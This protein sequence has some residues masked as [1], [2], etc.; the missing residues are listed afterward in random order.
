M[1]YDPDDGDEDEEDPEAPAHKVTVSSA[2]G[3]FKLTVKGLELEGEYRKDPL[4]IK[5]IYL[6][7]DV[8]STTGYVETFIDLQHKHGTRI[9]AKSANNDVAVVLCNRFLGEVEVKSMLKR[10]YV[11]R[12]R[13]MTESQ[14]DWFY[15]T[16][17]CQRALKSIKDKHAHAS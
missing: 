5:P 15:K 6:F 17:H 13:P 8:K 11:Y 14:P 4:K 1:Y 3:E 2:I 7:V 9:E 16:I 12:M 10:T